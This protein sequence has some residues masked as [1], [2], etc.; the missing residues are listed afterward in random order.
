M[1]S[2]V[3]AYREQLQQATRLHQAR[4]LL[5]EARGRAA[6]R[7]G[8]P[9]DAA[10]TTHDGHTALTSAS[11]AAHAAH[12][13]HTV[14]EGMEAT[15]T[16][17]VSGWPGFDQ[18]HFDQVY[19]DVAGGKFAV[20]LGLLDRYWLLGARDKDY[21]GGLIV[22]KLYAALVPL[23]MEA[24]LRA[25]AD[26]R[27]RLDEVLTGG[28]RLR[29]LLLAAAHGLDRDRLA[30]ALTILAKGAA[31][32]N[33]ETQ[34]SYIAQHYEDLR[35]AQ[36]YLVSM[37]QHPVGVDPLDPH[38]YTYADWLAGQNDAYANAVY[39]GI[40]DAVSAVG[41]DPV[42]YGAWWTNVIGLA[43]AGAGCLIPELAA[44]LVISA[45]A[46]GIALQGA[47]TMPSL[48]GPQMD[49]AQRVAANVGSEADHNAR[50]SWLSIFNRIRDVVHTQHQV[51]VRNHWGHYQLEANL[52]QHFWQPQF[53]LVGGNGFVDLNFQAVQAKTARDLLL[54]GAVDKKGVGGHL[55]YEYTATNVFRGGS[56]DEM[57]AAYNNPAAWRYTPDRVVLAVA[58]QLVGVF[59]QYVP[60]PISSGDV[61]APATIIVTTQTSNGTP[62][63]IFL[64][65]DYQ[66][67]VTG[68]SPR[69]I[70]WWDGQGV[71]PLEMSER[72]WGQLLK[73]TAWLATGGASYGTRPQV[74]VSAVAQEE[75]GV[76]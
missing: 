64:H 53:V 51:A 27:T 5:R 10:H 46:V 28:H 52:L 50:T 66:D 70:Y 32:V 34:P 58:P 59:G 72:E 16:A 21:G 73:D 47:S 1:Q 14:Q 74:P 43:V 38:D 39:A 71:R 2:S 7:A 3:T 9:T 37:G 13:G 41:Y 63:R 6:A 65:V 18:V 8:A 26:V 69:P 19:T 24:M 60:L 12:A 36:A 54:Q 15:R 56:F 57:D 4:H 35:G 40:A 76:L 68:L 31:F 48:S 22:A 45:T 33:H 55:V 30:Y 17:P 62:F 20:A 25:L 29:D 44:P 75:G 67:N 49:F 23:T 11:H 42:L 61:T